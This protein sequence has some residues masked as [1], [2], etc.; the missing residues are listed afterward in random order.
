MKAFRLFIKSLAGTLIFLSILF[1]SAGRL[2]YWQGWLYASINIISLIIN[3]LALR[4]KEELVEERSTTKLETKSWDKKILGLSAVSLIFTYIVGGL[5]AGR[6]YW[7]PGFNWTVN[8][9]G[10]MVVLLGEII[11]LMAQKQ[12]RFFSSVMRIQK[13][14]GHTVCDTGIYK[15]VRH[16]SYSG[17]ILTAI[18]IPLILGSLW[19]YI[20]SAF[21][22]FLTILRTSL[23]DKTLIRELDGYRE[24]TLKT[25]SRLIPCIW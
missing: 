6:F 3:S 8:M 2:N 12:N 24:Y 23:E 15:I 13:D 11:F 20:P 5:D 10:V 17:M 19:C 18:G 4:N 9:A 16:P 22:I 7:S 25:P 14:R 1:I 21:S